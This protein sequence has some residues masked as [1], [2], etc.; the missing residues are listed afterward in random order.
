MNSKDIAKLAGVSRSTVSRVI[1]NYSNVPEETRIK[2][3]EVIKKYN[4]VPHA[5][6]RTLAGGKNRKLGLFIIDMNSDLVGRQVSASNYFTPFTSLIVDTANK[7]GYHVVVSIVSQAKDY[8]KVNQLF[9]DK[10]INGG[11]FIGGVRSDE[12]NIHEL[13]DAGYNVLLVDQ[14]PNYN[15]DVYSKSIIVN[16]DNLKG[17]YDA[18]KYLI[19]LAHTDIAHVTG[20]DKQLST[21]ERL[22]GYT[23]ALKE[24]N[25]PVQNKFI[26]KGNFTLDSGYKATKKLLSESRPTAIF[27]ANDSMA[28]GGIRAIEE[29]GYKIPD[30]ISVIGFDDIEMAQYLKPALT[31]VSM[32][33]FEIASVAIT[34]LIN[35][36]ESELRFSATYTIPVSL[37]VRDSCKA[38]ERKK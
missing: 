20:G 38:L 6:A 9:Y 37:I 36:M 4:Y 35:V 10:T 22:E 21:V 11:I 18:T 33:L 3:L 17:A 27:Y 32:N 16:A 12:T 13:I 25:I 30:D 15:E 2:V 23:K 34:A 26:A 7:M 8:L 29:E 28:V 19:D 14:S 5:S 31:T 1:N 24:A